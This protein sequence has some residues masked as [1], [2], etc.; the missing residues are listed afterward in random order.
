MAQASYGLIK[1]RNRLLASVTTFGILLAT[2]PLALASPDTL[3]DA[4]PEAVHFGATMMAS[5]NARFQVSTQGVRT[6]ITVTRGGVYV[7]TADRP[8]D[9]YTDDG[10]VAVKNG[11]MIVSARPDRVKVKVVDGRASLKSPYIVSQNQQQISPLL[12]A[13]GEDAAG[14]LMGPEEQA[15]LEALGM[16]E[17]EPPLEGL[18]LSELDPQLE[19][20]AMAEFG[21]LFSALGAHEAAAAA[22]LPAAGSSAGL[23]GLAT[24]LAFSRGNRGLRPISP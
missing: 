22:L 8:V 4:P 20:L 15:A 3:V 12:L 21:P 18:G 13:A 2:V 24:G 1:Y 23:A 7:K 10:V 14:Q 9:V 16:S 11:E 19:G 5:P 17:E 6:R